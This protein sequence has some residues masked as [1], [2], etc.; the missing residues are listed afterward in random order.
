MLLPVAAAFYGAVAS[1]LLN[2]G[3][4]PGARELT[5]AINVQGLGFVVGGALLMFVGTT[6]RRA[7]EIAEDYKGFV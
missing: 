4:G 6:I 1:V 3:N 2:W 5:L 7:S